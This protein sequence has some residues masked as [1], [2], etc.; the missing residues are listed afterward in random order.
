VAINKDY[1]RIANDKTDRLTLFLYTR[2]NIKQTLSEVFNL[3]DDVSPENMDTE[4]ITPPVIS[5]TDKLS[6]YSNPAKTIVNLKLGY[7]PRKLL[8][9]KHQLNKSFHWNYY[10]YAAMYWRIILRI[11]S[12]L[13]LL[14]FKKYNQANCNPQL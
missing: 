10:L 11:T 4:N 14:K 2:I 5:A 6:V 3:T 12:Q 13:Y 8:V 1:R 9:R 7:N